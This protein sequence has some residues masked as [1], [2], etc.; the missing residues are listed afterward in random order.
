MLVGLTGNFGSGKSTVLEMFRKAGAAVIDSDQIVKELYNNVHIREAAARLLGNI[1]DPEGNV[2]R[3]KIAKIVFSDANMK[4]GLENILHPHVIKMIREF[5][6]QHVDRIVVA[7][8]PLLFESGY[9]DLVDTT[10]LTTCPLPQLERRLIS[11]GYS[12]EDIEKRLSNQ[13]SDSDKR[14]KVDFVIDTDRGI[15]DLRTEVNSIYQLLET[16]KLRLNR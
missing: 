1:L 7:E 4:K 6:R 5:S 14:D 15:E 12:T 9:T 10:I 16:I 13:I 2:D 3:N 11:K 8:I